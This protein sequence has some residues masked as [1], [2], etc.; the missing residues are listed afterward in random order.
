MPYYWG[1]LKLA[2]ANTASAPSSSSIRSNWLY[3]CERE[4]ISRLRPKMAILGQ[5]FASARRTGLDLTRAKPNNEVSNES[6]LC[7][8][9][10]VAYHRAPAGGKSEECSL[11]AFG[12]CPDLVHFEEE[13]IAG[14]SLEARLD[15]RGIGHEQVVANLQHSESEWRYKV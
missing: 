5:S 13:S 3:L 8:A 6:I 1:F 11:D 4:M 2:P 14:F 7:L 9:T 12:D 15:A 10:S